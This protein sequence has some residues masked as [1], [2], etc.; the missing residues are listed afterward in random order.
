M[1]EL[2]QLMG[3]LDIEEKKPDVEEF[4]QMLRTLGYK[5]ITKR[6]EGQ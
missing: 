1:P 6:E 4:A 3:K 5:D 2:L